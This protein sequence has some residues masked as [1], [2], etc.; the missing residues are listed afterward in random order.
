MR[1]NPKK[2]PAATEPQSRAPIRECASKPSRGPVAPPTKKST[3]A[4][5]RQRHRSTRRG[6]P[7]PQVHPHGASNCGRSKKLRQRDIPPLEFSEMA[8]RDRVVDGSHEKLFFN[9]IELAA[10]RIIGN[11]K[12]VPTQSRAMPLRIQLQCVVNM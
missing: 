10:S 4:K 5:E 7:T 9:R 6:L 2:S 3:A 12:R 8:C 1:C 11:L